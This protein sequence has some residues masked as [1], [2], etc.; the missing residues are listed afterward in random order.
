LVIGAVLSISLVA[1]AVGSI[2]QDRA[3]YADSIDA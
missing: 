3:G 2:V 1:P